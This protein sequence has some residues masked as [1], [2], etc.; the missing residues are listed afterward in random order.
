MGFLGLVLL[1]VIWWIGFWLMVLTLRRLRGFCAC[2]FIYV[3]KLLLMLASWPF[4][5]AYTR[6]LEMG[7]GGLPVFFWFG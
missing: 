4:G 6:L 1:V 3:S 5:Y 2:L 7:I